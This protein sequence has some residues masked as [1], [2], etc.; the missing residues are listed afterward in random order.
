MGLRDEAAA[1]S[2]K[3]GPRTTTLY[4]LIDTL[5]GEERDDVIALVWDDHHIT[6][7]AV[8]QVLTKHY[9]DQF[10]IITDQQVRHHRTHKARP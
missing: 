8:A 1:L 6:G 4:R 5:S 7:T 10:G 3:T 9:G 2:G